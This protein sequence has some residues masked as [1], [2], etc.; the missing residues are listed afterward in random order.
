MQIPNYNSNLAYDLSRFDVSEQEKQNSH[1]REK[2]EQAK[3]EIRMNSRSVSRSGST[4]NISPCFF[5]LP[6][7]KGTITLHP[8]T[9]FS[10]NSNGIL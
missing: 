1:R 5:R 10:S 8:T 6:L 2:Q 3:Q 4:D 9:A 7:P